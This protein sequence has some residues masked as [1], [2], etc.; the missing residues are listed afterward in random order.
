MEKILLTTL[1]KKQFFSP[2]QLIN[3]ISNFRHGVK[4]L[5]LFRV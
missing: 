5:Q 1:K 4:I 3:R 2:Y